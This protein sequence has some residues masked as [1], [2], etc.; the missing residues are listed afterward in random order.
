M[1]TR[2][3]VSGAFSRKRSQRSCRSARQALEPAQGEGDRHPADRQQQHLEFELLQA[4]ARL[5]LAIDRREQRLGHLR[6]RAAAFRD[7]TG[8]ETQEE[9][10]LARSQHRLYWIIH[11]QNLPARPCIFE[12]NSENTA[13]RQ[14]GM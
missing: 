1:P 5:Q 8:G 10:L 11:F 14:G 13:K 6:R 7:D 4:R 9:A 2:S 12:D 3:R